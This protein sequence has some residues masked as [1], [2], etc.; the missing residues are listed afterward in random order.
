[1]GTRHGQTFIV[2]AAEKIPDGF[3]RLVKE[4]TS[5]FVAIL[6]GRALEPGNQVVIIGGDHALGV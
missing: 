3:G 4:R 5:R 2:A 1:V 6:D